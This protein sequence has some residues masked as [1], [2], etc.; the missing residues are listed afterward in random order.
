MDGNTSMEVELPMMYLGRRL[1]GHLLKLSR[2]SKKII[3][4]FFKALILLG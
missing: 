4:S 1:L 2:M 3:N